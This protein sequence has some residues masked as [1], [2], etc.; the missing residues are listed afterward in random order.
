MV[1]YLMFS[2]CCF[3]FLLSAALYK[4]IFI[5]QKD[6]LLHSLNTITHFT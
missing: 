2:K 1:T 6:A 3:V 4:L 5:L